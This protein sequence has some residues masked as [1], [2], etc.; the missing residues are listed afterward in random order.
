VEELILG[1]DS[2]AAGRAGAHRAGAR[3]LRALRVGAELIRAASPGATVHVSD[4]TWA[5]MCPVG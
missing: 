1:K 2:A 3:R 5:I 4:P